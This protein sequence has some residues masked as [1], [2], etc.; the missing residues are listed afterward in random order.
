MALFLINSSRTT[1]IIRMLINE[2]YIRTRDMRENSDK[3]CTEGECAVFLH[4]EEPFNKT[5]GVYAQTVDLFHVVELGGRSIVAVSSV[6]A[7][8]EVPKVHEV[9]CKNKC[10]RFYW[11]EGILCRQQ[12]AQGLRYDQVAVTGTLKRNFVNFVRAAAVQ[13]FRAKYSKYLH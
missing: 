11:N 10:R 4:T 9:V 8:F 3:W 13:N 12:C 7:D 6:Y 5:V 2:S 1:D